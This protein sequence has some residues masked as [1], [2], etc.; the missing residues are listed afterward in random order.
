MRKTIVLLSLIAL[1]APLAAGASSLF[2]LQQ[3]ASLPGPV[4]VGD[5][6]RL[7]Y[8]SAGYEGSRAGVVTLVWKQE[9]RVEG[10]TYIAPHFSHFDL[11]RG[12]SLV[13]RAPDNSRSWT[14]TGYGKSDRLIEDGFWGI[15]IFR[16]HGGARAVR[17]GTGAR[18]SGARGLGG[19]WLPDFLGR[20]W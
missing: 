10:A 18:R 14:F 20:G 17:D 12:A 3:N 19:A 16:R 1:T 15:H 4:K 7:A 9:I 8:S 11:P 5:E 6:L 13:V 2:D